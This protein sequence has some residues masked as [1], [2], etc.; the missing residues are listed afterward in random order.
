MNAYSRKER[1]RKLIIHC[2][3]IL[4]SLVMIIPFIW[5]ILTSLKSFSEAIRIPVTI[6]PEKLMWGNY[7]TAWGTLPFSKLFFNTMSM[8]FFRVLFALVFSSMAG[9][10]FAKID[11]PCK[12]LAFGVVVVQLMLPS[13]MFIIPQYNMV[14]S[15]GWLNTIKALIFPGIVSAFGVFFLR[16]FYLSLPNELAEAAKLDGC[17]QW[18]VFFKIMLPL[19]K[20]PMIALGIFTAIFAWSDLMWPLI[21]NMS[22]DKMTLASGLASLSGQF[23][24][25]YPVLMAGAFI[26]MWPMMI[27]YLI[28]QKQ[29]VEGIA[30]TG[31]K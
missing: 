1:N 25:D 23:S 17:N 2:I 10:A 16:Q 22:M 31:G 29:F 21:V 13:Q 7:P 11:F 5:M 14:A 18:Q 12:K 9:Y 20:T 30:L 19:T 8:M 26:A 15:L 27:I 6:F 4:G 3:L 28:F 24:T